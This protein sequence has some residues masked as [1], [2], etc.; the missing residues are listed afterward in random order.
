MTIAM[1]ERD[2]AA[3]ATSNRYHYTRVVE[4]AARTVRARVER[5]NYVNQSCAVAEVL[6]DQMT[7]TSLAADAP[8]NWWHDTPKPSLTV[9]ATTVLGPL[10]DTLL[11]RAAEI[12]AAPPTTRTISPHVHGA[13]SA[14]LATSAGFN[15]EARIDPDDIDW[16]YT[17][18]GALHII[19]HPDGSVTF[20]KAH[21][22]DCPF[23]TSRGAQDCD[24]DCYFPHPADVE[25]TPG[26]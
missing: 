15:A 1:T 4:V 10:T 7:W 11:R 20:T 25:R 23:I 13:I 9:H 22:E 18:G 5:D 6:N 17:W 14:L 16:A 19:E 8:A 3:G 24:E 26:R 2:E 12:L 21:R